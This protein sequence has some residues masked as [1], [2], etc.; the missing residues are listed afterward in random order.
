M[1]DVIS[2]SGIMIWIATSAIIFGAVQLLKGFDPKTGIL[3]AVPLGF[4][5]SFIST[6][7]GGSFLR[8]SEIMIFILV[9]FFFV[10]LITKF[11]GVENFTTAVGGKSPLVAVL[12]VLIPALI[13]AVVIGAQVLNSDSGNT[14]Q[15]NTQA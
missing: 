4:L 10:I 11:I 1:V 8:F 6:S 9:F 3:I 15:V 2:I 12:L 13:F 14:T 5:A 7:F